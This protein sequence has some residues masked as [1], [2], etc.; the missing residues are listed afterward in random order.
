MYL[1]IKYNYNIL[2]E[3]K[4]RKTNYLNGLEQR[5]KATSS[6]VQGLFLAL[7]L[8]D[9]SSWYSEHYMRCQE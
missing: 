3:K 8:R 1:G 2:F 4:T 5:K 9:H 6:S 7:T